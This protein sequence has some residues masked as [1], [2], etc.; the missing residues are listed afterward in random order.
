MIA[1]LLFRFG[2]DFIKPGYR[3][4]LGLGSIQLACVAGLL[5]YSPVILFPSRLTQKQYA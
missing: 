5:Y 1:Y 2:L 3:Y 4:A